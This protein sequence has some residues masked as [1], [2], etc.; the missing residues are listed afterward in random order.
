MKSSLARAIPS[1]LRNAVAML[2]ESLPI[3]GYNALGP[4]TCFSVRAPCATPIARG[5]WFVLCGG[6]AR[7]GSSPGLAGAA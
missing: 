4:H 1:L 6:Y 3:A 5:A 7:P 2:A